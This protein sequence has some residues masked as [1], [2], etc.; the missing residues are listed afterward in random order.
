[1]ELAR[2]LMRRGERLAQEDSSESRQLAVL[3]CHGAVESFLYAVL[4]D[5]ALGVKTWDGRETIGARKAL[6][7]LQEKLRERGE[8]A[9]GAVLAFRSPVDRL[10][11]LRDE[12]VHKGL[13]VSSADIADP[14]A[15]AA[16]FI[17]RY[18]SR[19]TGSD[20]LGD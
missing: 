3:A 16:Q 12:I 19:L 18:S 11:Y 5:P 7:R 10:L 9:K 14:V 6:T 17:S 20:L 15:G 13:Q 1:M 8:L 4:E 2:R